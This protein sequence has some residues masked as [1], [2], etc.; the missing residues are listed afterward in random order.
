MRRFCNRL[1]AATAAVPPVHE[2]GVLR[3][4]GRARR[5]TIPMLFAALL[6]L[7]VS[8]LSAETQ[9]AAAAAQ[10]RDMVERAQQYLFQTYKNGIPGDARPVAVTAAF[11]LAS[12]S[13]GY[14]PSDPEHGPTLTASVEWILQHGTPSFLGGQEEPLADHALATLMLAE[15]LGLHTDP[16]TRRRHFSRCLNAV[17]FIRQNQDSGVDPAYHGGWRRTDQTRVNDRM[18]T[19][20]ALTALRAAELRGFDVPE[21]GITRAAAFMRA[22]QKTGERERDVL[23]GGYS[24]DAQGLPVP[25]ATS[26]GLHILALWEPNEA[27]AAQAAVAWLRR[28][29]PR[30]Y[31]PN[32]YETHFFSVRGLYRLREQDGGEALREHLARLTRILRERQEPDGAFP[33]PPGHGGPILAM[34][35]AYSTAM[36]I[37]IL[38]ADRGLLPLDRQ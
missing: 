5:H 4:F 8:A 31:G 10:R 28:H 35:R 3:P 33:F 17:D 24:L 32:F 34:G 20:W 21:N 12:L 14:L 9:E 30:W 27:E 26:A 15:W 22:S 37:L 13:S 29:P 18:L 7:S 23:R 1:A 25:S 16:E 2:A 19:A 36:A 38:N 6:T 11:V